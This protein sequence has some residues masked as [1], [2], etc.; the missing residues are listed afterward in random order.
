MIAL[1][2]CLVAPTCAMAQDVG[3]RVVVR[4]A[5]NENVYLAGGDVD[6]R[7]ELT[8]DVVAAGGRV[9]I[10]GVVTRDVLVAGGDITVGGRVDANVRAAGGMVTLSGP[11]GG[12]L[13]AAGG[14]VY[15][16]P[17]TT[18]AGRAWLAGGDVE[19]RGRIGKALQTAGATIRLAGQ[20]DGDV[21]LVGRE[22][23]IGPTARIGGRLT[24]RSLRPVR[25]DPGA[26]ISGGVT[27]LQVEWPCH[28]AGIARTVSIILRVVGLLAFMATGVVLL[29]LFPRFL[30]ASARAL[31][32][33]PW[34]SLGLGLVLFI[35]TPV[36]VLMLLVGVLGIPLALTVL[37]VYAIALLVGY[38]VT[39]LFLGD[40]GARLLGRDGRSSRGAQI[41]A[42]LG[43]L[44]I[45]AVV[46]WIPVVGGIILALTVLFGLGAVALESYQAYA[47]RPEGSRSP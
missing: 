36:I 6:V 26:Q 18:V 41:L 31:A 21:N 9:T 32:T 30:T 12:E 11:I 14:R 25:I 42:L 5:I 16:A 8:A 44:V 46:R 22:I 29:L 19:V 28:A 34:K 2:I 27:Q 17:E 38:L 33:N 23:E 45:L 37:A 35:A 1:V 39:A 13:L 3:S 15:L 4:G 40:A 7:A 47:G 20:V 10:D 24:Y 43:G